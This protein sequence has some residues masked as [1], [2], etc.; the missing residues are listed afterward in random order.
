MAD[1]VDACMDSVK[2]PGL[3]APV[4][5][6]VAAARIQQLRS[7]N[8]PVLLASQPRQPAVVSAR[9]QKYVLYT[10]FC[11][12]GGHGASLT[13]NLARVAR[14]L[15]RMWIDFRAGAGR[16]D[17]TCRTERLMRPALRPWE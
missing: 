17:L 4:D 13:G 12:I 1:G 2:A 11:G 5:L 15:G 8:H 3:E 14:G 16:I 7:A 6:F 10:G 9:P